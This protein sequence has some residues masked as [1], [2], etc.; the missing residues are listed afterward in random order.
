[1]R[2]GWTDVDSIAV[3]LFTNSSWDEGPCL[4][5][6]ANKIDFEKV[7][8]KDHPVQNIK[9][10]YFNEF[11]NLQLL[12]LNGNGKIERSTDK[13]RWEREWEGGQMWIKLSGS[14]TGNTIAPDTSPDPCSRDFQKFENY[15]FRSTNIYSALDH[16][17][18]LFKKLSGSETGNTI[19]PDT[20]L[21]PCSRDFEI[22]L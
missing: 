15:I 1:M 3:P 7:K 17:C 5:R 9:P 18:W 16:V 4:D 13:G 2:R 21:G 12:G 20:S 19:A 14:E 8:V 10:L 11:Q 6:C 22:Y